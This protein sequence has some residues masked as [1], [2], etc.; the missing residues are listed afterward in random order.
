MSVVGKSTTRRKFV[1]DAAVGAAGLAVVSQLFPWTSAQSK[2]KYGRFFKRFI[3][4]KGTGGP[5]SADWF[6]RLNGK[7]LEGK[8]TNFSFGYYSKAGSWESGN[9]GCVSPFDECL[10]FAG[11]DQKNPNYL[12]AE[13]EISLGKNFEKHVIDVPSIVCVPKNL[14]RGPIVTRKAERPFA[15]Y[16]IGLA[17]DF[18]ST[19]FPAPKNPAAFGNEYGKLIKKM[20]TTAMGDVRK[21]G[22]GNA[23]WIAWPKSKDL[24][25]FMVNFSWGFYTGL[26]PWHTAPGFDPHI[27]EGDEFLVFVSLDPKKP[28]DLGAEIELHMGDEE[29]VHMIDSPCVAICP[30][31]FTH[32]PII[33][34]KVNKP[35]VFFLIRRDTGETYSPNKKQV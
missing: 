13:I 32:A 4:K 22:P 5:G 12:G 7:D 18:R 31:M 25:G 2:P 14:P 27:H 28:D 30:A 34:K 23:D 26:G 3:Y 9:D 10:V 20:S 21:V 35:Y 16:S 15:H 8:D 17:G 19:K 6:V 33:T 1:K 29:E 24:D 11:L